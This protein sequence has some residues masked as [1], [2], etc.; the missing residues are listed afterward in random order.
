MKKALV[1]YYSWSC[2][3]TERIAKMLQ[4]ATGADIQKIDK[5]ENTTLC[6]VIS[7]NSLHQQSHLCNKLN[8]ICMCR[9][10]FEINMSTGSL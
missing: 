3:N 6:I 4:E 5:L 1:L 10:T 7:K 8:R 2:G 9:G